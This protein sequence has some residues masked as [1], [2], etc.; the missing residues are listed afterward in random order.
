M[1]RLLVVEDEAGIA[2]GLQ[3][4][5]AA[6]GYDVE[7]VGDGPTA[8][9]RA[10]RE[11]YDLILL[12]VMLPGKDGFA[13]CRDLRAAGVRTPIIVL[14][15]RT[16]EIDRVLGFELGADDYV[17][18]PFSPRELAARVKAVLRRT[19]AGGQPH[20]V[21][22][23]GDLAVD[24]R[25]FE[26]SRGGRPLDLTPTE[27]RLLK[28]FVEHPGDVL[29][30]RRLIDL[31]WGQD[32]FLTDRVIYTHVNNLRAKI[33][34]DPAAPTLIVSIRRVGYRFDG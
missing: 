25:R 5:L 24:F 11:S 10:L 17:T 13:V 27:F 6:E 28:T 34:A 2:M 14:T 30:V 29:S 9:A 22:R 8:E 3:D 21:W 15:A 7:I 12:D 1:P 32:V 20:D 16:Q 26:A 23:H 31:V 4:G 33:E 18:K 19:G